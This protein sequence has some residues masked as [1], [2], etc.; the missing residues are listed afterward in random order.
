VLDLRWGVKADSTYTTWTGQNVTTYDGFKPTAII[1]YNG[2]LVRGENRGYV[3]EHRNSLLTDPKPNS[4][5][6]STWTLSPI[7]FDYKSCAFTFGSEFVKKYVT[8]LGVTC[9]NNGELSVQPK[10]YNDNED[11]PVSMTQIRH[12]LVT[13]HKMIQKWVRFPAGNLR[14]GFKA[15]ELTNAH[16]AI[17]GSDTLGLATVNQG[18][19]TATIGGT[20]PAFADGYVIAFANDGY[21]AEFTILTRST[22]TVTYTPGTGPVNGTYAWVIRGKPKGEKMSIVNLTLHYAPLG[23]TQDAYKGITGEN[24]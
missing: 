5:A 17:A 19:G 12:R 22:N 16:V 1:F 21:V 24:A 23:K 7:I 11:T 18:A 8:R 9:Q 15:V 6:A 14:C 10:S 3:F 20:M 4:G 2:N 13:D